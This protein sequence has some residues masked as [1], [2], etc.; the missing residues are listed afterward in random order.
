MPPKPFHPSHPAAARVSHPAADRIA[1][2]GALP[3]PL[4]SPPH[5]LTTPGAALRALRLARRLDPH[6]PTALHLCTLGWSDVLVL[7]WETADGR[8]LAVKHPTTA[9]TRAELAR[10]QEVL[11]ALAGDDRL[12]GWRRLLPRTVA[13]RPADPLPLV[14]QTWLPGTPADT[15][16]GR[17][18]VALAPTARAALAAVAALHR[19]TGRTAD[20]G[21]HLDRWTAPR[22]ASIALRLPWCR[23]GAAAAGLAGV[24]RRLAAGLA[25]R[26]TTVAWTHGDFAPG[27]VLLAGGRVTGLVDWAGA[28]PDGPAEVDACTLALG[29]GRLLTGRGWGEQ[30]AAALRTGFL[31]VDGLDPGTPGGPGAEHPWEVVLLTWLWHVSANLGKSWRFARNRDWLRTVVVPVLEEAARR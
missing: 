22:L 4:V 2:R 9:A 8:V 7:R 1:V 18:P 10:E 31:R 24:R 25:G 29:L 20:G 3:G 6:H 27:N 23:T 11:R 30:V 16:L 5:R 13:Y 17:H 26:P 19:A 12:G 28:V 21:E 14:I 15:L